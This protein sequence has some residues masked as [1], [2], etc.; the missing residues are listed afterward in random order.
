MFIDDE[1]F[2]D[3]EL[4]GYD[5]SHF[6]T[7][8]T[9]WD[10]ISTRLKFSYSDFKENGEYVLEKAH[11]NIP[12][13]FENIMMGLTLFVLFAADIAVLGFPKEVDDGIIVVY[14]ISLFMFIVEW[15]LATWAKSTIHECWPFTKWPE[16]SNWPIK[17]EGYIFGFYFWLDAIAIL[18]LCP[19]I[20][21]IAEAIGLSGVNIAGNGGGGGG[22]GGR[23]I[24]MVR[25]V[26]LVKLYKIATEKAKHQKIETELMELV[27]S[28]AIPWEA[29][30]QRRNLF[31]QRDSKL[32]SVLSE[33]ITQRVIVLVLVMLLCIPLMTQTS[34]DN[35]PEVAIKSLH[36]Y[37][38]HRSVAGG[39]AVLDQQVNQFEKVFATRQDKPFLIYLRV[40]DNASNYVKEYNKLNTSYG[41]GLRENAKVSSEDFDGY[42]LIQYDDSVYPPLVYKTVAIFNKTLYN[43]R[44]A[45][46]QIILTIFVSVMLVI[47]SIV[48]N[49]DVEK[50]VLAPI[51]K[52]MNL[53]DTIAKDPLKPIQYTSNQGGQYET[54]LLETTIEKITGL[55]RVG[56]GEAGAGIISS[57]LN[58]NDTS[59]KIL[60][61]LT[62][63]LRIYCIV[64]F[65]DI[66]RFDEV[67]QRMGVDVLRFVNSIA[68]IVH[69]CI[70]DWGGQSNKNLGNAFVLVWRIGDEETL[71]NLTSGNTGGTSKDKGK[72]SREKV[73][74]LRRVPGIDNL[75]DK[76]L[77]G[78]LKIIVELNRQENILAYRRE[79][80]LTNN[81]TT[82]FIVRMGFGLHA[83]WAIEGAVGSLKKIDATYLSP[84]VNMAARLETSSKQYGVPVLISQ[85]AW[86]LMSPVAQNLC[87]KLDVVT[88]KGSE[89]P[90]GI[91]TYDCNQN[92]KFKT[93]PP[94]E[95][96]G[97]QQRR[98][99]NEKQNENEDDKDSN[100][101]GQSN[102]SSTTGVFMTS[103]D[104]AEICFEEDSDLLD[105]RSHVTEEF[106]T[107]FTKG[108]SS[109]LAG[110][111][112]VAKVFLKKSDELMAQV[113]GFNGDGPSQTLLNYMENRDWK[114]PEDWAGYRPLTSK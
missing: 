59:G 23:V 49:N 77:I 113:E 27:K 102:K 2:N 54:R 83:G 94:K 1:Y 114:A 51:D 36:S 40:D 53:V 50:L 69:G 104:D 3:D 7:R 26:R 22:G 39:T 18:S 88:V 86:E 85:V 48:L 92:A 41:E 56:F 81:N 33:I 9:L 76:A 68:S 43:Y 109:Y 80:R 97:Q 71:L 108:I 58:I 62:G 84:H 61:P 78:Y 44:L 31:Q 95:K 100:G 25:L 17:S 72:K 16:N 6:T 90:I 19:D 67:N 101:N 93:P 82:E 79:A 14:S 89:F 4:Y 111:W 66:H 21:W 30:E 28:G 112:P 60:D 45:Y 29:M 34:V 64:G 55:L 99:S 42:D 73:V 110:D 5:E 11:I 96:G 20:P 91:Y 98:D 46:L 87:R 65:C 35:A 12:I 75:A 38:A 103:K 24:R 52:M 13:S 37:N 105:L 106:T 32:S 70:Q 74:D 8:K 47:G 107:N 10:K 57:S 15:L 63:G